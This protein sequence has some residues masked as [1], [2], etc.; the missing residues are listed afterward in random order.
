MMTEKKVNALPALR[1]MHFE[2]WERIPV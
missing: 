2:I 1:W